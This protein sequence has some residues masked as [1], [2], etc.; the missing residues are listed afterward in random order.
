MNTIT[1]NELKNKLSD[2]K[3]CTAV[4][5][6][7]ETFPK[8]LKN[9]RN[10]GEPNPYNQISKIGTMNGLIGALYENS[11]NNQLGRED[12]ELVFEAQARKW[13]KLMDNKVLVV[14]TP[15]NE[16]TP[17]Y[18][19][20]IL[21]KSAN[22]PVYVDEDSIIPSENL[23]GLLPTKSDPKTQNDIDKKVILRD[24]ALDNITVI[25]MFN[26]EYIVCEDQTEMEKIKRNQLINVCENV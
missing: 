10:T 4:S 18:Y 3:A 11:C 25:R 19:L 2:I 21:V 22:K 26:D 12:K 8:L 13:G 9:D 16:T 20:Q 17:K 6:E 24:V 1:R 5:I 23:D 14:H 7:T 15:K